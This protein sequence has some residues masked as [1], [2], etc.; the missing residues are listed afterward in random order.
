MSVENDAWL[1]KKSTIFLISQDQGLLK[2]LA[3][4]MEGQFII[5]IVPSTEAIPAR[6]DSLAGNLVGVLLDWAARD[7]WESRLAGLKLEG[8]IL[9]AVLNDAEE[10]LEA[11]QAGVDDV[12]LRPI[13]KAELAVRLAIPHSEISVEQAGLISVGRLTSRLCHEI[14]NS[15]QATRG[16]LALALE[17][18][19]ISNDLDTYLNL[20]NSELQRV[21]ALTGRM[22]NIYRPDPQLSRISLNDLLKEIVYL[23]ADQVNDRCV[24]LETDF[25]PGSATVTSS[26]DLLFL[27]IISLVLNLCAGVRPEDKSTLRLTLSGE[28]SNLSMILT[29]ENAHL[30]FGNQAAFRNAE[31]R[32]ESVSLSPAREMLAGLGVHMKIQQKSEISRIL[33]NFQPVTREGGISLGHTSYP[34]RG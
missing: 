5:E 10:R 29:A 3:N 12:L 4:S 6:P 22:R 26:Y 18:P 11:F 33:L 9:L 13:L 32:G 20:C 19:A 15:L 7:A 21:T 25:Q 2:E 27:A 30:R 34:D 17:E 1:G 16:A 23:V 14:N 8:L 24:T 31:S 28:S